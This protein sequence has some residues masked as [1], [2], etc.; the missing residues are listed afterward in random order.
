MT[1][2]DDRLDAPIARH[3]SIGPD[4]IEAKFRELQ[5]EVDS[6]SEDARSYAVTV[7]VVVVTA[8]VVVGFLLGRRRGRKSATVFEIRRV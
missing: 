8:V 6:F 1:D 3:G 2:A 5:G 7:A 4:D